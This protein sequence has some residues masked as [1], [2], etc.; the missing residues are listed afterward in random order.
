MKNSFLQSKSPRSDN[1]VLSMELNQPLRSRLRLPGEFLPPK[2]SNFLNSRS[3]SP[4]GSSPRIPFSH[5]STNIRPPP[6]ETKNFILLQKGQNLNP[7]RSIHTAHTGTRSI[8][9]TYGRVRSS[10][11][12]AMI[13]DLSPSL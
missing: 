5:N 13:E 12:L 4:R 10:E 6:L 9:E 11:T 3:S 2:K 8:F 7:R 1:S